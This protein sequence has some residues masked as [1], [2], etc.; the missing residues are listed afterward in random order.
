[1]AERTLQE[2]VEQS[3]TDATESIQDFEHKLLR[4]SDR[5]EFLL[6]NIGDLYKAEGELKAAS[7]ALLMLT[8][9]GEDGVVRQA[10]LDKLR[11]EALRVATDIHST[12]GMHN[13]ANTYR[14]EG[15]IR[16]IEWFES[17]CCD[18]WD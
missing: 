12:G 8:S 11:T 18:D 6:W 16:Y 4:A 1:M 7:R 3:V 2:R 15:M 14:A 10:V 5:S 17:R 13:L 9:R